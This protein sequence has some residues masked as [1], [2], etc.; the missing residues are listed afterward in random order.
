M[1]N[2]L[3]FEGK[4][5]GLGSGSFSIV[6]NYYYSPAIGD[7]FKTQ[8]MREFSEDVG[9][10]LGINYFS[11]GGETQ[12]F[13]I[14]DNNLKIF[15]QEKVEVKSLELILTKTYSNGTTTTE[16]LGST[17]PPY[18]TRYSVP[19]RTFNLTTGLYTIEYSFLT[20]VDPGVV[21]TA[22]AILAIVENR[23]PLKR[24][25]V[26]D[27]INRLLDIAEPL[28]QGD[29][30]RFHLDGVTRNIDGSFSIAS[31]SLA[32][33]LDKIY[34]PEWA[35]TQ[36]N[37]R[38]CLQIIGGFI[39]GEPR[40]INGDTI[41]YDMYGGTEVTNIK[42]PYVLRQFNHNL[43]MY[44][45]HIDSVANNLINK[46]DYAQGVI[47][48]PTAGGYRTV[49]TETVNVRITEENM[50]ISTQ[51]PIYD[52]VGV[53]CKVNN[54]SVDISPY[55]F[56]QSIYFSQLSSYR[57][58]YPYS[59]AY[60]I[61]FTK[62]EK[63]IKGL[64]F[65]VEASVFSA[66]KNYAIVNILRRATGNN[67][68]NV[69]DFPLL[70]FQV[71]YVPIYNAR[72]MQHKAYLDNFNKPFGLIFNQSSNLIETRYYGENIKGVVERLGKVEETRTYVFSRLSQIPKVGT[73]FGNSYISAVH[74]SV[75]PNCFVTTI[76]LSKDF[77]RLS[78]YIGISN[79]NRY[80]EVSE[81]NA[82]LRNL[83][84]K[85]Y[86]VISKKPIPE[87]K[88]SEKGSID[89]TPSAM[90][91]I[92]QTF[93]Q[94]EDFY[95]NNFGLI[96]NVT[97]TGYTFK[98][99]PLAEVTLPVV[100]SA[101]GNSL[102][103]S[104]S[105]KDNY[106][107]GEQVVEEK[108]LSASGDEVTGYWQTDVGY[109]DY[110]GKIYYY[111]FRLNSL[112]YAPTTEEKLVD[113]GTGYPLTP[114]IS[115]GL[116]K[117][118]TNLIGSKKIIGKMYILRKDSREI[119]QG[120]YQVNFVTNN[121]N[122]VIGSALASNCPLVTTNKRTKARLYVL[123][124]RINKFATKIDDL[125][126]TYSDITVTQTEKNGIP[127][128]ELSITATF[129]ATGNAWVIAFPPETPIEEV[130]EDEFGNETTQTIQKGNEVLI[131]GNEYCSAGQTLTLYLRAMKDVYG[132]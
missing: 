8:S 78:Q 50:L 85:E 49:R 13:T 91:Y 20:E 39:H 115:P 60:G 96:S 74:T 119:I 31:G 15:Y 11:N 84:Y 126:N 43:E 131:A 5:S 112:K 90:K 53:F 22:S 73:I 38:E 109:C 36:K 121:Q 128:K 79:E 51:Y 100:S 116:F 86:I 28:H 103:F 18:N 81:N 52:V 9:E 30:P 63:D 33:K 80:Y 106:S 70:S 42:A 88:V 97:A 21:Y 12:S 32:D 56:E 40:L 102:N 26:T 87:D 111:D 83:L 54:E 94:D 29:A 37:L 67:N 129:P 124:D 125:P 105:Y 68:L 24:L 66:F 3:I 77:N 107:A 35:F 10:Q 93:N 57:E 101:F 25:T 130:V 55:L 82:Y 127:I 117:G 75:Y 64:N 34:A 95:Q 44:C 113:W 23:R 6:S 92:A 19:S 118:E 14:Y 47:T 62:G 110:Y 98:K 89:I 76:A 16:N 1:R 122:I 132:L 2:Y 48:E 61:Y 27:V 45:T 17:E 108:A 41:T 69:S 59:K 7:N 65:R 58:S 104:W 46:L 120:N 123:R 99:S 114:N 4:N 71:Q 72:V